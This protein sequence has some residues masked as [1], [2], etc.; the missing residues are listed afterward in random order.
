MHT[1]IF[2]SFGNDCLLLTSRGV[3]V[4]VLG[5]VIMAEAGFMG[6]GT[7]EET[8]LGTEVLVF[9]FMCDKV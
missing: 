3:G 2:V 8:V 5:S 1:R 7:G 6:T 9:T 4:C